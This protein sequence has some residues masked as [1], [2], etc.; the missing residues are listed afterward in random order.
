MSLI[1]KKIRNRSYAY[2]STREGKKIVH[3]YIGPVDAPHVQKQLAIH[4]DIKV[5]PEK[6]RPLFWDTRLEDIDVKKNAVYIIERILDMGSLDALDWI[7]LVYPVK[8]ILGVLAASRVIS[9]KSRNFWRL[10]FG[11]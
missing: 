9:E 1:T 7:Q 6:F 8:K 3:K 4:A 2:I 10:W 11:C 5:I